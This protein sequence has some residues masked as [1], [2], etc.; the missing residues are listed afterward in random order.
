MKIVFAALTKTKLFIWKLF[1]L[2]QCYFVKGTILSTNY[3]QIMNV[4]STRGPS[5]VSI[6]LSNEEKPFF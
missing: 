5:Y 3:M 4:A 1:F 6:A 2:S